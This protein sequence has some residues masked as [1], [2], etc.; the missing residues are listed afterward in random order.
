MPRWAKTLVAALLV[1]LCLGF[2]TALFRLLRAAGPAD[3]VW[4]PLVAGAACW[5]VIYLLLP[6]P[7]W[8]YVFGHELT[9]ALWTWLFE[10]RVRQFRVSSRG[11][12]VVITKNNFL[13][14]LA[15]YFFPLYAVLVFV[16]F[17]AASWWWSWDACRVWFLLLLG[18]AYAFH[19]TLTW[20]ALQTEQTDI[21]SQG[22]VFSAVVIWLG[23]VLVLL[24]GLPLLVGVP[25][26]QVLDWCVQ[27]T[28]DVILSAAQ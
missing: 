9:H 4:V 19:L 18:A 25:Y 27:G 16:V 20:H 21:T 7:M 26:G 17:G 12:H 5:W 2:S 14:T 11:G 1:P 6:R 8:V 3:T 22:Y 24:L 23:S 10:G 28:L 13:I 15:P